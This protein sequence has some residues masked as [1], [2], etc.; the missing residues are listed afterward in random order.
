MAQTCQLRSAFSWRDEKAHARAR[1]RWR[2]RRRGET[3]APL[4]GARTTRAGDR[5]GFRDRRSGSGFE[6]SCDDGDPRVPRARKTRQDRFVSATT[7]PGPTIL[8][9]RFPSRQETQEER[10]LP[11]T[12]RSMLYAVIALA[13]L[14]SGT[15]IWGWMR[16]AP[17][18]QVVRYTLVVDSTEAMVQGSSSSGRLAISP[19]GSRLAYIG[20]PRA[21]LLIRPRNQLRATAVPGTEG[22]TTPFFS[23][24]GQQVGIRQRQDPSDRV[25]QRRPT[26]H[27]VRFANRSGG[28]VMGTR[29]IHLRRRGGGRGLVR[30][31]GEAGG[32]AEVVYHS[33]HGE[34]R[35]RSHLARRAAQRKRRAVHGHVQRKE[36]SKRWNIVRHR[37][38][39]HPLREAPA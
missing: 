5:A 9:P 31:E 14:M 17:P 30:V 33:G 37:R 24:D 6:P 7:L 36:R 1:G 27:R 29:R 20:G 3:R 11:S 15:A 12:T 35:D 39:R 34:R 25:A 19:D 28:R 21:Q 32:S 26:D 13:I 22:A 23:P 4:P 18:E 16:P 8:R 38:G 10:G 2:P